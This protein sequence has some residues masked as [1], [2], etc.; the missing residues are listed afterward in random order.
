MCLA[1]R[2]GLTGQR[3]I[4]WVVRP[5]AEDRRTCPLLFGCESRDSITARYNG[6]QVANVAKHWCLQDMD[7]RLRRNAVNSDFPVRARDHTTEEASIVSRPELPMLIE[8]RSLTR[9]GTTGEPS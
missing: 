9:E 4:T 5:N 2:R 6:G 8:N 1:S 3:R 7:D